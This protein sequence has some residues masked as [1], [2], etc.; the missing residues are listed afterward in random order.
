MSAVA[1]KPMEQ[2][3]QASQLAS[4]HVALA[5]VKSKIGEDLMRFRT[6]CAD[7]RASK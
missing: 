2:V 5:E 7:P 3:V 1:Q 4:L 6:C